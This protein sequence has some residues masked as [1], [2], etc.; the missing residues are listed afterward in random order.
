MGN[1]GVE[2]PEDGCGTC[3]LPC[4]RMS[5]HLK[6]PLRFTVS[7]IVLYICSESSCKKGFPSRKLFTW[8]TIYSAIGEQ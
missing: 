8:E 3:E 1:Y 5:L 7:F 6:K 4:H 2:N